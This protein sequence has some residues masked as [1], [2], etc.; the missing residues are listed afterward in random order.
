M[1]VP[2]PVAMFPVP[3]LAGQFRMGPLL[4]ESPSVDFWWN[5]AYDDGTYTACGEP[6]GWESLE[7]VTPIDIVGGRDGGL[8]GPQSVA[9]RMLECQALIVSPAADLLRQHLAAIRRIFGPQGLP[10]PRQP[11]IWEQNDFG[12]GRRLALITRPTGKLAINVLPGH[13]EGGVAAVVTFTLAAVNPPWKYQAGVVETGQMGLSNPALL[14]GRT[15]DKTYNYNYGAGTAPGGEMTVI[16]NGDLP[17]YPLFTVTGPVD[18]PIIDNV[19]TGAE[20]AVNKNMGSEVVTIDASTGVVTPS[21][22]RLV[23]RPFTLAPGANTI[24]WRSASGTYYPA[25]LLRLD[26]RSTSR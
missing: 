9:P 15:Y 10:G 19:T 5:R 18:F 3:S 16:N 4:T 12:S 7:Y 11:V 14:S 1:T 25:A 24:R 17:A 26:W 22:V 21:S 13:V 2:N 6:D 20:F 8:T 23:G